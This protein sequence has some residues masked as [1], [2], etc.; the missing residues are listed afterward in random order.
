MNFFKV[1]QLAA[2]AASAYLMQRYLRCQKKK[3]SLDKCK[4]WVTATETDI[5][6]INKKGHDEVSLI[7]NLF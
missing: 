3:R 5:L 1:G 4:K 7:L 2:E 6:Q